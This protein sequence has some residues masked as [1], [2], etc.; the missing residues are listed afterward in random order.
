ME[1]ARRLTLD[2]AEWFEFYHDTRG[3]ARS[4]W[5]LMSEKVLVELTEQRILFVIHSGPLLH[6]LWMK[7]QRISLFWITHIPLLSLDQCW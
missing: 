1:V 2:G 4:A 3:Q 6:H 5:D 7:Q